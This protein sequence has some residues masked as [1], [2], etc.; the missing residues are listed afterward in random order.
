MQKQW[1]DIEK[2]V[3]KR[4]KDLDSEKKIRE[5]MDRLEEMTHEKD[6][7]QMEGV[8]KEY[9]NLK[10]QADKLESED[11]KQ[12]LKDKLDAMKEYLKKKEN[13]YEKELRKS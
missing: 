12:Q 2:A 11:I 4:Q 7:S 5:Y 8:E 1:E 6:L 3:E 9:E 10:K 13:D